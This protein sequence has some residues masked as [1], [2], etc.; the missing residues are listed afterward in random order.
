MIN[1]FSERK[2]GVYSIYCDC[3]GR[4]KLAEIRDNKLV[5]M[6]RRHGKRHITVINIRELN[7]LSNDRLLTNTSSHI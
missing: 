3:C 4:E 2:D 5:I 7:E 6:D 1:R